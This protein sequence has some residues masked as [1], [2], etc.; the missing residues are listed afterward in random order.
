MKITTGIIVFLI[1]TSFIPLLSGNIST[2]YEADTVDLIGDQSLSL[3]GDWFSW[4]DDCS[5][6]TGWERLSSFLS[7][8]ISDGDYTS[9]G[10]S[11]SVSGIPVDTGWHGPAF[12]KQLPFDIP[13]TSEIIFSV[14]MQISNAVSGYMGAH[15]VYLLDEDGDPVFTAYANDRWSG[16][17][18]GAVWGT[19]ICKNGTSFRN[20]FGEEVSYTSFDG[21][22]DMWIGP[23]GYI[24]ASVTGYGGGFLTYLDDIELA[25]SIRYVA[26][27]G[28][29]Y[30]SYTLLPVNIENILVNGTLGEPFNP[31]YHTWHHDCS[32]MTAFSESADS[33]WYENP[34][35]EIDG[36]MDSSGDYIYPTSLGTGSN[37]HGPMQYYTFP[38]SMLMSQLIELKADIEVDASSMAAL[39]AVSVVL[40]DENNDTILSMNVADSWSGTDQLSVDASIYLRNGSIYT[41]PNTLL[42]WTVQEPY[43]EILRVFTNSTGLWGE[44]PR[45]GTFQILEPSQMEMNRKIQHIALNFRSYSTDPACDIMRIHDINFTYSDPVIYKWHDDCSSTDGWQ[46]YTEWDGYTRWDTASGTLAS[47]NGYLHCP[48][49]TGYATGPFW[50]KEFT[51]PFTTS[52]F[53]SWTIKD[54]ANQ[55]SQS[56]KGNLWIC[57]FD[58]NKERVFMMGAYSWDE[59]EHAIH[60]YTWYTFQN[61]SSVAYY[62]T[63]MSPNFNG[64]ISIYYE[65][66][67]G[68]MGY[69][70]T[71]GS[72]LILSEDLWLAE[73]G[74]TIS[75]I[76]VQWR[77]GTGI[78]LD[79]RLHDIE[80]TSIG[81]LSTSDPEPGLNPGI[82]QPDDVNLEAGTSGETITWSVQNCNP[83]SYEVH[84]DGSL[85]ESGSWAGDVIVSLNNLHPGSYTYVVT[86]YD[87]EGVAILTD[88][89]I[90]TVED[91]IAPS[92]THPIDAVVELGTTGNTITWSVSDLYPGE[93]YLYLD[94]VLYETGS[95]DGSSISTSVDGHDIG[96]YDYKLV[97]I[98]ESTNEAYDIRGVNVVDTTAPTITGPSDIEITYGAS[99]IILSWSVYD[100]RPDTFELYRDGTLVASDT[101]ENFVN[102][103]HLVPNTLA[104]GIYEYLLVVHDSS[105]N[106]HTSTVLV[107]VNQTP[108]GTD[109]ITIGITVGSI[110]VIIIIGGAIICQKKSGAVD[111]A[112]GFEYG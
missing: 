39:G 48:S 100:L 74:R 98:D 42:V 55:P 18:S 94:D 53:G 111:V 66:G 77:K 67:T 14:D 16:H 91:T 108:G 17:S 64:N 60:I 57:L 89:V 63:D 19:Y 37:S 36:S 104:T 38:T 34:S 28:R 99:N 78:Y 71:E 52:E 47:D 95:W 54:E 44:F 50:F 11:I 81:S 20:G 79:H 31:S 26:L 23:D 90:V 35:I 85:I 59:L 13:L 8:S 97:V 41:T 76:G 9:D 65:E 22:I 24:G 112:A 7:A 105:G 109:F 27:L 110:A 5:N 2:Y 86:V 73:P 88:T 87:S 83:A 10:S 56:Y 106:T 33:S 12:R 3:T 43:R 32:N 49:N 69:I 70:E 96:Q 30:S 84:R 25:R 46:Y 40:F 102:I 92:I 6:F 75:Y 51:D 4:H 103:T 15:N 72:G 21:T 45:V 61:G 101:W 68:L 62:V 80:M 82:S 29:R 93:Y 1:L 107:G 58:Q